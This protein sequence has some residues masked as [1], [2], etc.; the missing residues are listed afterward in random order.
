MHIIE[1]DIE[2]ETGNIA[3]EIT[4]NWPVDNLEPESWEVEEVKGWSDYRNKY[5]IA[6]DHDEIWEVIEERVAEYKGS[7]RRQR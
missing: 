5:C 2:T 1:T 7:Y 3:I 4:F 6:I